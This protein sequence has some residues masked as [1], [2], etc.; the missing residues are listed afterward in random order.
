MVILMLWF[1]REKKKERIESL[2]DKL[3]NKVIELWSSYGTDHIFIPEI[4][5]NYTYST[6]TNKVFTIRESKHLKVINTKT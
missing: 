2:F 4:Y 1:F 3:W 5:M 6:L